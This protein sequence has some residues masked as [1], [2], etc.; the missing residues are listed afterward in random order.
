MI[1]FNNKN[2]NKNNKMIR[3]VEQYRLTQTWLTNYKK[4][5]RILNIY[6]EVKDA[7]YND[8]VYSLMNQIKVFKKNLEEYDLVMHMKSTC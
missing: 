5:L 7:R 4:S 6:T 3:T 8:K 1:G 2:V